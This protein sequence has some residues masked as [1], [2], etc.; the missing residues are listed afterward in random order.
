[1][2]DIGPH[3][4]DNTPAIRGAIIHYAAD[5]V[6]A[7]AN[8]TVSLTDLITSF[9]EYD[10]KQHALEVKRRSDNGEDALKGDRTKSKR[11]RTEEAAIKARKNKKEDMKTFETFKSNAMA[12]FEVER[13]TNL[14]SG[15]V[16]HF[17]ENMEN[18]ENR[19]DLSLHLSLTLCRIEGLRDNWLNIVEHLNSA[20]DLV[21]LEPP[22]WILAEL[23]APATDTRQGD[24]N[25]DDDDEEQDSGGSSN[26]EEDS[27][28]D[29]H[30][31]DPSGDP[32]DPADDGAGAGG[33]GN[34]QQSGIANDK[35]RQRN[36]LYTQFKVLEEAYHLRHLSYGQDGIHTCDEHCRSHGCFDKP[37]IGPRSGSASQSLRDE[38]TIKR[39]EVLILKLSSDSSPGNEDELVYLV[40]GHKGSR[41]GF[42]HGDGPCS[43]TFDELALEVVY[44]QLGLRITKDQLH[45][46]SCKKTEITRRRGQNPTKHTRGE[47]VPL[48]TARYV[49]ALT[50][51]QL[52]RLPEGQMR[53]NPLKDDRFIGDMGVK[54]DLHIF[55]KLSWLSEQHEK[56]GGRVLPCLLREA[57]KA[58]V[59]IKRK[60]INIVTSVQ[61]KY[62]EWANADNWPDTSDFMSL[63]ALVREDMPKIPQHV[64][65]MD[66]EMPGLA[67]IDDASNSDSDENDEVVHRQL[68]LY[69]PLQDH[70]K[71]REKQR[72]A[73]RELMCEKMLAF[74]RGPLVED[75]CEELESAEVSVIKFVRFDNFEQ[76]WTSRT[77]IKLPTL[78]KL[79]EHIGHAYRVLVEFK[80]GEG[81]Q[82]A[83]LVRQTTTYGW[84]IQIPSHLFRSD[85]TEVAGAMTK[86]LQ[87]IPSTTITTEVR[88]IPKNFTLTADTPA[89]DPNYRPITLVAECGELEF[90][91]EN[92][93]S[94]TWVRLPT[95]GPNGVY[96]YVARRTADYESIIQS[97]E[98]SVRADL[99][100]Q[101]ISFR[102][103]DSDDESI[104]SNDTHLADNVCPDLVEINGYG[105]TQLD[106]LPQ[107]CTV[108]ILRI[109]PLCEIEPSLEVTGNILDD[110]RFQ[111]E[112]FI[113]RRSR[114]FAPQSSSDVR[115][116]TSAD[117]PA[118]E[119]HSEFIITCRTRRRTRSKSL[120]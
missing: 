115:R 56:P 69:L 73:H 48:K 83:V 64:L 35:K 70:A 52:M 55:R 25:D 14:L 84:A 24:S 58:I 113:S 36:R 77:N 103:T 112:F 95:V 2:K 75:V 111:A 105:S 33:S 42:A 20:G 72:A 27:D 116:D 87:W 68:G 79:Q 46:I 53:V 108:S 86:L 99:E 119:D 3:E 6:T 110:G 30:L 19:K 26:H 16:E 88:S 66:P 61:N 39:S 4:A 28:S 29:R 18:I 76:N 94:V 54:N 109:V 11:Q 31:S 104:A 5:R 97:G 41:Y 9:N 23:K 96:D 12:N 22:V 62:V 118:T 120:A 15:L 92:S 1:V 47:K 85:G 34:A 21:T 40:R 38:Q 45:T 107:L 63:T 81:E 100:R 80:S 101:A 51:D 37:G 102:A 91:H 93:D 67:S 106:D 117:D 60:G 57:R 17:T 71:H 43:V 50:D 82:R 8:F 90:V 78:Q 10:V 114:H 49:L 74:T 89:D 7:L 65:G 98:E 13:L 32:G 59:L 44:R